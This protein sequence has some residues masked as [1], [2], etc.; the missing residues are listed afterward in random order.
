MVYIN[1]IYNQWEWLIPNVKTNLPLKDCHNRAWESVRAFMSEHLV[2]FAGKISEAESTLMPTAR[3]WMRQ[4][5]MEVCNGP[6]DHSV[7]V[8]CICPAMGILSASRTSFILNF[9]TNILADYPVN[10]VVFL[11]KPNRAGQQEGRTWVPTKHVDSVIHEWEQ[12]HMVCQHLRV[13][14]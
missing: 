8:L 5:T 11:V 7:A 4:M 6:D 10:G 1:F 12:W 14:Y 9:I 13:G 2:T 3:S